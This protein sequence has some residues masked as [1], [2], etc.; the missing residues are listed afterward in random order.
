[1]VMDCISHHSFH[2][3]LAIF[4]MQPIK[5]LFLLLQAQQK[6]LSTRKISN[7]LHITNRTRMFYPIGPFNANM[8]ELHVGRIPVTTA[9]SSRRHSLLLDI[10]SY[11]IPTL[12]DLSDIE[13]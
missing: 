2:F 3:V 4:L 12:Y 1:M 5:H 6:K 10:P 7:L 11:A 8:F 9:I 13:N